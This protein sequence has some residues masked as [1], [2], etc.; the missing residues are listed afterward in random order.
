MQLSAR[1]HVDQFTKIT[2]GLVHVE[3][4]VEETVNEVVG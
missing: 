3:S 2:E 4:A 1:K